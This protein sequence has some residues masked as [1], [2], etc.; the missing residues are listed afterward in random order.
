MGLGVE[1]DSSKYDIFITRTRLVAP[2]VQATHQ[3]LLHRAGD[4]L[5]SA[6]WRHDLSSSPNL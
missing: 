2:Y 1:L 6:A 3:R 4:E 5:N